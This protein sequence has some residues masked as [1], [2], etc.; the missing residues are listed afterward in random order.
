MK[1]K[2]GL[3]MMGICTMVAAI[4]LGQN[5]PAVAQNSKLLAQ[6]TSPTSSPAD[7][8]G[9]ALTLAEAQKVVSTARKYVAHPAS[10]Q[11]GERRVQARIVSPDFEMEEPPPP[12]RSET[13]P[14][15]PD[16]SY[17]WVA[18]H[19][20]P[21]KGEWRWVRGEWAVPATPSSVWIPA[22][23]DAKEKKWSPGYWQPDKP[24]AS[25]SE[26]PAKDGTT[27]LPGKD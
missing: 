25:E 23:Y 8:S 18:G 14:A 4:A 24:S 20:M 1:T 15:S 7:R 16:P 27:P 22:S 6:Q 12:P 26:P 10:S 13:K 19:Y 11:A 21:V 2:I 5:E 3:G 9:P 17:V